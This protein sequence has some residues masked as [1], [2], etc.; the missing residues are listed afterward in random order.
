MSALALAFFDTAHDLYGTARSG[1]TILFEGSN[2]LPYAEGPALDP[3]GGGWRA[4]L[5]DV[6]E[7]ELDPVC[8][9]IGLDGLD[10]RLVRVTGTAA[11]RQVSCLGTLAETRSAPEWDELDALRTLSALVDEQHAFLAVARR[12][13]GALGHGEESVSAVLIEEGAPTEVEEARLST[14][15]D[16]QGRQRSAGLELWLPGE[17]LPRR[18]SGSV[19]AGSSLALSGLEVHTAVFRW[20][21]EGRD[22]IGAYEL[23]VRDEPPAAA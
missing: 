16:G 10:V 20:R 13:R 22:G 23:T 5:P 15:Y 12:P 14:V 8:E 1:A 6:L 9:T 11:G 17:E 18:G 7:L 3:S 4:E 21:L 19:I 2:P